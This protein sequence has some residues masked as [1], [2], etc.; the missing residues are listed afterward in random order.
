MLLDL[1]DPLRVIGY[2]KEP[3]IMPTDE[4]RDGYVP[5]VVYTCGAMIHND[6]LYIPY[7]TSDSVSRFAYVSL[8]QLLD[9]LIG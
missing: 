7:A 6:Y 5:N 1:N 4:D 2:L 8:D 9:R 3:L